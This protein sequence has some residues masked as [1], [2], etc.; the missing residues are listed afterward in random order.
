MIKTQISLTSTPELC[1]FHHD[2]YLCQCVKMDWESEYNPCSQVASSFS[3][4]I[5]TKLLR[6]NIVNAIIK[7]E[8]NQPK[9]SC[10]PENED[11]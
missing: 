4:Q 11:W 8:G 7:E 3:E 6:K 10:I 1:L 9:I 2:V 5:H